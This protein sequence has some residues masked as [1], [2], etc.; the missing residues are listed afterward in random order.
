MTITFASSLP[1]LHII[2]QVA[3]RAHAEI[4]TVYDIKQ[5]HQD[6]VMD[7]CACNSNGCPLDFQKLLDFPAFDFTHDILGIREHINRTTGKLEDCF[8]PRCSKH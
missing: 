5:P 2:S 7:L 1:Q 8:M 6:T 3:D 4:F